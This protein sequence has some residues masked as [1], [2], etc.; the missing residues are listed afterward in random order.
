[1]LCPQYETAAAYGIS[2]AHRTVRCAKFAQAGIA[3]TLGCIEFHKLLKKYKIIEIG[4][5]S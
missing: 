3:S 4:V 1:M 2:G 5:R